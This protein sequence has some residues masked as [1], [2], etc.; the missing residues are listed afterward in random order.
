MQ[1]TE[2]FIDCLLLAF[3]PLKINFYLL[4][5]IRLLCPLFLSVRL[6]RFFP[7]RSWIG[8]RPH[9]Q[10]AWTLEGSQRRDHW[11]ERVPCRKSWP[12]QAMFAAA[13]VGSRSPAGPASTWASPCVYSALA[14]T[15]TRLYFHKQILI[16]ALWLLLWATSYIKMKQNITKD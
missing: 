14:S 5:L 10:G 3:F 8:S 6:P 13:T 7:V 4:I 11:K 15:G 12:S 16:T 9:Q 2:F 1:I